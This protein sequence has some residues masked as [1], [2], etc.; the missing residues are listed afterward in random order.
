M[1]NAEGSMTHEKVQIGD[2]TLY[3]GDCLDVLPTL[4]GVD[5]V[6]TDPPYGISYRNARGDIR[7][8]VSFAPEIQGDSSDVGQRVIDACFGREW[9]VC[10]FA[11]H[12]QPWKGD[13]RQWLVWDKGGAVGG[14]GDIATCWKFT[15]E[16]IQVSGFGRLN[17]KRDESVLQFYIG[18]G[19]MPDH[20]TQ[21]PTKLMSYLVG[22]LTNEGQT[23]FDPFMGSGTT[24][25]SCVRMG[26]PFIGCE[27]DPA[28]FKTAC[29]RIERAYA[30]QPLL[31]GGAA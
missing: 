9:P 18:Q 1:L 20:P 30:D 12:R 14:G 28:Y 7:P 21:K 2:C 11:H 25:V 26:R 19:D 13:W 16:L 17:G 29:R 4:T 5:A 23:V 15:W 6:V 31:T 10:A 3:R 27:I 24:G 8:H 22:K